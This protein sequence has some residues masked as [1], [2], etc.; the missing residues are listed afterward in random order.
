MRPLW[1][2]FPEDE[3]AFKIDNEHMVGDALLVRTISEKDV[4]SAN[5]Y[6]PGTKQVTKHRNFGFIFQTCII[7]KNVLKTL[8]HT[9]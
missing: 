5:V 4:N 2:E 9:Q 7:D 6:F 8:K 3:A 1:Y